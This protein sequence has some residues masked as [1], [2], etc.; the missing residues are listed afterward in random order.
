MT[1]QRTEAMTLADMLKVV[2]F[3]IAKERGSK[4]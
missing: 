3:L 4:N 2:D 1:E